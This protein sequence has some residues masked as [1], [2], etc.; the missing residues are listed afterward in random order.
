MNIDLVT[1]LLSETPDAIV[2]TS[3]D[4]TV[5]HWSR[6]AET[7]FGYTREEAEGRF[8]T[9]LVVPGERKDDEG[10]ARAEALQKGLSVYESVRRR[11]D[12][13]LMYVN[14]STKAIRDASGAIQCFLSTKRDVTNLKFLRDAK[15]VEAKLRDLLEFTPDA[16]VIVNVTG[17]IVLVNSQAGKVFGYT[18][19]QLVGQQVEILLPQ[20]FRAAQNGHLGNC[21]TQPRVRAMG[22]R[23]E[24]YCLR[25]TGAEFS[26]EISLS[27]FETE[28][29][30]LVISS[31]RD[32][33][34]RK[35]AE[36]KFKDLLESAPDAMVIVNR[37]GN[38]M[39]IN[40]QTEKLF[41][42]KR[43]ELLGK[44]VEV[45]VPTRFRR[46]L[47]GHRT[48][49]FSN[50]DASPM[51]AGLD[52]NGL[53][54][55]GTK[56]PVEISLSPL[57]T[58]EA[59]FV[60]RD[61]TERKRFEQTLQ[62]ANR[63]KSE[64]LA[65]MSHELRTPLNGI[66][67]FSEFL[68]DGKTGALTAKQ[69]EY[70]TDILN[71]GQHLLQLINNVLDLA[72]VEAGKMELHPETFS[73]RKTMEEVCSVVAPMAQTKHLAIRSDVDPAIDEVT[74]DKQTFKQIL[75]NLLSN[76]VKFTDPGGS[77]KVFARPKGRT[78][79][80]FQVRDTGIGIKAEDLDKLFVEFRQLDS[81]LARRH[82]GTGLG[83]A[84]T[85]KIVEFQGGTI[86]IESEPG[87]GSTFTVV[88]P[89]VSDTHVA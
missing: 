49:F 45:L 86:D 79:L 82:Q 60:I 3:S 85:K 61:I 57:E 21:F 25:R 1:L 54:S 9:D 84:L 80:R 51:D 46:L 83:L 12:G 41:G 48:G 76:A 58:E 64:F 75:Y 36:K 78:Q 66:I 88:L 7:I 73:I 69:S 35:K 44:K 81:G 27:P 71:S 38:I 42:W 6:A 50:P 4:D 59:L 17:R 18:R 8:L 30:T 28:E 11:K 10:R 23:L 89:R 15:L 56:F 63:L 62:E 33:T 32:I 22:A 31:I 43:E 55:D 16:I 47:P 26:V 39:L 52:L 2:A 74:L 24:L 34:D 29:G 87:K 67:G 68:I 19:A 70:I 13:S 40:S 65:N 20:R 14:I 37:R 53:R 77:V 72:K 5:L